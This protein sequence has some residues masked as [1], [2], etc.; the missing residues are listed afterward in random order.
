MNATTT[1]SLKQSSDVTTVEILHNGNP[2]WHSVL[3]LTIF[4]A[5]FG[6][7]LPRDFLIAAEITVSYETFS[8]PLFPAIIPLPAVIA[9]RLL[10]AAIIAADNLRACCLVVFDHETEYYKASKL[11]AGAPIAYRGMWTRQGTIASGLIGVASFTNV[12]WMLEGLVFFLAALIP[13]LELKDHVLLYQCVW[14]LW[15]IVAPSS[16]LVSLIVTYVLWPH[17][18]VAEAKGRK[19]NLGLLNRWGPL[20][21]HNLN[22]LAIATEFSILGGI[23]LRLGHFSFAPLYGSAYV[24]FSWAMKDSWLPLLDNEQKRKAWGPQFIY[25]F[26]DTS[27]GWVH[28]FSLV[29]LLMVLLVSH[30]GVFGLQHVLHLLSPNLYELDGGDDDDTIDNDSGGTESWSRFGKHVVV[31]LGVLTFVCRFR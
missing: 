14:I 9:I 10:V 21:A 12:T 17:A 3:V 16:F 6:Y 20:L 5:V 1:G 19:G 29:A 22:V 28:T 4:V 24:L 27:L 15:E 25:P 23:P 8:R 11:R 30:V 26:M 7:L 31:F 18:L 13:L 2:E